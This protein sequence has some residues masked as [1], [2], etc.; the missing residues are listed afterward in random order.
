MLGS[1]AL[2]LALVVAL[3][4]ASTASHAVEF[5]IES[6][7][8]SDVY[9]LVT[10]GN[11][12][13]T[14]NRL[15]Q[16][17]GLS[18]YDL[19]GDGEQRW[20]T[21]T[22]MRFDGEFGLSQA[23][24]ER[25]DGVPAIERARV[26]IQY[27]YVEAK[28]LLGGTF[29]FR[30]GRQLLADGL[31][32]LM[33]DGGHLVFTTPWYF[34]VELDGGL[35]VKNDFFTLNDSML[36][37]DGTRFIE[38]VD[39]LHQQTY[40]VGAA[41]QTS[42]LPHGQWRIA[43]RRM[44]E[45]GDNGALVQSEHIGGNFRQ[46]ILDRLDLTGLMAWNLFN[47]R[48]DRIQAG[49]RWRIT[50]WTELDAQYV[51]MLPSFAGD[52]IFNIF[53]AFPL[54]DANL[55]WRLLPTDSDRVYAGGMVRLFGN[56]AYTDGALIGNVKTVVSAWGAMAGWAHT[57]GTKGIDGSVSVDLSLESGYG[58]DRYLADV[59][60]RWAIVPREWELDGRITAVSFDD[61]LQPNSHAFSFGY[62][63]SGRY[64]IDKKAAFSLVVEHNMNRIQ[65]QQLRVLALVDL[66]FWL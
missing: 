2:R 8:L 25:I 59:G 62:Q 37:Q 60:G 61:D 31:D 4:R 48:F 66:D 39:T 3:V 7:T 26:S 16:Y 17:L 10:S 64:L 33:F 45:M 32:Y 53:T 54:N 14:R 40:L 30:L 46:Q 1:R 58:G 55:R 47:G 42:K 34:Q 35:E 51:R 13:L 12:I 57:F 21:T 20:S 22:L 44:F 49:A 11:D 9:Q 43:Y 38:N 5:R 29:G 19:A 18:L 65:T 28:D 36:E 27:A 63:L 41:I 6:E 24:L 15:H 52:S 56:E 23:T 50:D